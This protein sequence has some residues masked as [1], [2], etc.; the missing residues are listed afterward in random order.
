MLLLQRL[1]EKN[2]KAA[3]VNAEDTRLRNT[4]DVLDEALRWFGD[5]GYLLIDEVTNAGDWEGWLARNYEL[6]KDRLHLIVTSSR[7]GLS[8]PSRPLRGRV[9]KIE[10]YPLSFREFLDFKGITPEKTTVGRGQ[11]RRVLEEYVT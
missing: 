7:R 10:V 4:P 2:Q 8:E 6:L 5:E 1:N 3:Y 9:L 11:L